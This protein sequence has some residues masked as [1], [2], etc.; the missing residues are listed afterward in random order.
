MVVGGI[1]AP[2]DMR[3]LNTAHYLRRRD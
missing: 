3:A 2:G 1:D